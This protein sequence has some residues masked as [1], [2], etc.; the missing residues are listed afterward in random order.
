MTLEFS[1]LATI[2]AWVLDV[3]GCLVRTE[4]AGGTGGVPI[5]G[6]VEFV[7][8]LHDAGHAVRVVTN[9]SQKSPRRYAQHLRDIGFA[10]RDDQFM[11]A[12]SAAAAFLKNTFDGKRILVLGEDGILDPL[13]ELG[14]E[15]SCDNPEGVAAVIVGAVDLVTAAQL[16]AAC[17]A[18]ADNDAKLYVTV[19]TP[20]FHGGKQRS[21]CVSAAVAHSITWV[22]GVEPEVLGKPSIALGETLLLELGGAATHIAVVGDAPAEITLAKKMGARSITVLTGALTREK[23]KDS[24]TRPDGLLNPDL[25][26]GSV[27]DLIPHLSPRMVSHL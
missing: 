9:A 19:D 2:N 12:G 21:I 5:E 1:D 11:T 7:Q 23:L 15:T 24:A 4:K 3:D 8:A 26:V 16:N 25:V 18:V 6:A 10:I 14:M 22:T 13:A 17:I 20:W 27:A